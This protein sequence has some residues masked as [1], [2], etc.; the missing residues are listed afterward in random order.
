[1]SDN[2]DRLSKLYKDLDSV[3]TKREELQAELNAMT[4]MAV[5]LQGAIEVL[6]DMENESKQKKE[7]KSD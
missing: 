7:K 1:M 5:K 4:T 3:M 6:E 2:K